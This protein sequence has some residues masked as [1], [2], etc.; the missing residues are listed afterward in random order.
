[1]AEDPFLSIDV[2]E[3]GENLSDVIK[4]LLTTES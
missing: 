2:E 1:M 3:K 4:L